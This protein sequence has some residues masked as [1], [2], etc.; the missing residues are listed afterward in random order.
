MNYTYTPP[1]H[2]QRLPD[3][4]P[5]G[6]ADTL[7]NRLYLEAGAI[8]PTTESTEALLTAAG[9]PPGTRALLDRQFDALIR[10]HGGGRIEWVGA[11]PETLQNWD[12]VLYFRIP[13]SHLAIRLFPGDL[14]PRNRVCFFDVFDTHTRSPVNSPPSFRFTTVQ[15]EIRLQSV[16]EVAGISREDIRPGEERFSVVEGTAC[17]LRRGGALEFLFRIPVR[18]YPGMTDIGY[19]QPIPFI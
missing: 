18:S 10:E 7:L 12:G 15:P 17:R 1:A 6:V 13:N 9:F 19:T 14:H 11:K 8:P 5:A 16:E 2:P 3:V 4:L